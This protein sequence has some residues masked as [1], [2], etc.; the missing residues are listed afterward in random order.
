MTWKKGGTRE[1]VDMLWEFINERMQDNT[2]S[3]LAR[4]LTEESGIEVNPG[5][6]G[7]VYKHRGFSDTLWEASGL[8]KPP[9]R[10]RLC[11]EDPDGV[12]RHEYEI[13]CEELDMNRN[14]VTKYLISKHKK[15][16][17]DD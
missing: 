7:Y 2:Y 16:R 13:L 1:Q 12:L 3:N 9:A 17:Q 5:S 14:Q 8:K 6:V 10:G 4:E 15:E 11:I